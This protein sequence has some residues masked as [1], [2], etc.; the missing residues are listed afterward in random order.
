MPRSLIFY[1]AASSI[2]TTLVY[3][4]VHATYGIELGR[5]GVSLP[6]PTSLVASMD[7]VGFAI[8]I[9]LSLIAA[10]ALY[11]LATA[12][13]TARGEGEAR[14]SEIGSIFAL[15]QALT[16]SLE[17]GTIAD[18]YLETAQ[19]SLDPSA[20][21]A[22]YVQDDSSGGFTLLRERGPQTGHLGQPRY[23]ASALPGPVRTRVVDHQGALVLTDT[24]TN[25]AWE[26]L[27]TGLVDPKWIGSFAA[28]PLVSHER[29]VG[30]AVFA[31]PTANV[32]NGNSVQ[33]VALVTQ[34]VAA[35]VRTSLS[36]TEAQQRADREAIVSRVAQR[37]RASL[38]PDRVLR[39]A[40][41]EL[42]RAVHV[43]RA[44]AALGTTPEEMRIAQ[45]W[46]APGIK[47]LGIGSTGIKATRLAVIQ[48][49]TVHLADE[50]LS[51]LATPIVIGGRVAGALAL[52]AEPT[53]EWSVDDERLLEAVAREVRS[54]IE[55]ARLFQSRERENERL[56]ALQRASST[57]A[58]RSTTREVIDE[59]LRTASGLLSGASAS[60]YL[61]DRPTS[62]LRL[63]QNADPQGRDVSAVLSK[64]PGMSGDLLARL[65]PLVIND[66]QAWPGA[67]PLGLDT[68]MRA[69]LAVP[70]VRSGELVG[71]IVL[72]SYEAGTQF[73]MDDA[74][75]LGLFG[76]QAV[77]ALTN[78]EA[79]ERQRMAMEQLEKVNRAKSEFVS[80][81][82]HEFRTPLTGIQGFSE[83]MR[84]EDLTPQEMREYA[85]DINKDAQRLSRM[86]GE[87]LDLDRME[88]G[89]MS[90]H[91]E[92]IDLNAIVR[93]AAER[94][95]P[96]AP[97]HEITLGLAP[98]LPEYLGDH[99]RLTQVVSN[100]LSNAVK[101][102]PTGGTI[103]LTSELKDGAIHITVA[104][105]G[106]GIPEDM[107]ESIWERYTRVESDRTRGIQ[108]TGLGL[109]IVRQIVTMHGGRVWAESE[110]G[111]GSVFHVLL[112]LAASG[113]AVEA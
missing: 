108:G 40:V 76:D 69:V 18:K 17:L 50:E 23:S 25:P 34:F 15:G 43:W 45:E 44:L 8:W 5:S 53:R 3:I 82:S 6:D 100:L 79:F 74:R 55:A 58:A 92:R 77:A 70:L 86:I 65:E 30:M 47:P 93:E 38:D 83:I 4:A 12:L 52:H 14:E 90:M 66:Y 42:G 107:L 57:V 85:A 19:G 51:R 56:L 1:V 81:V 41:D 87:M 26:P 28:L 105:Q 88:A 89:R 106:M 39:T 35:A 67:S 73:T 24:S 16:G 46:V 62:S 112:P 95:R 27:A 99:D 37:A 48:G 78:A 110:I 80:I 111:R 54:A 103:A 20:T 94:L 68:G 9:G 71:A 7:I 2:Y 101:Y 63:A 72:R 84:D 75:L 29:L 61:W 109:P 98:D 33:L 104:D 49:R 10:I 60:L 102:S 64:E 113:Q 91:R 22:L 32:V 96:N 31:A 97:S 11:R 59:V 21:C 36:F 13:Q